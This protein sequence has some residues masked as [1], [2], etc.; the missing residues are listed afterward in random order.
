M[1]Q[2]KIYQNVSEIRY[3]QLSQEQT[4]KRDYLRAAQGEKVLCVCVCVCV[5]VCARARA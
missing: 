5:C 2:R 1:N 4:G 3:A